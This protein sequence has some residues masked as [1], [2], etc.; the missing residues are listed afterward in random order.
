MG[1]TRIL[2]ADDDTGIRMTMRRILESSTSETHEIFEAEDGLS[3]AHLAPPHD[4]R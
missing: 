4:F 1:T 3:K 2:I